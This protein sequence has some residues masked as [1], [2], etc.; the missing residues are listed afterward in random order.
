MWPAVIPMRS[1][2]AARHLRQGHLGVCEFVH[3]KVRLT[4]LF[5]P[6]THVY[7]R[8]DT[9]LDS[10]QYAKNTVFPYS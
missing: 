1:K 5:V 9:Y 4:A 3:T 6:V 10:A 8:S 2:D 7:Y